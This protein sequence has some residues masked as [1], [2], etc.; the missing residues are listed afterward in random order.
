MAL[1]ES[2]DEKAQMAA[3]QFS[4]AKRLKK[5]KY[6]SLKLAVNVISN[7]KQHGS[8]FLNTSLDDTVLILL[9]TP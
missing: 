8:Q 4:P 5:K 3:K 7:A 9:K 6:S 2:E 1:K